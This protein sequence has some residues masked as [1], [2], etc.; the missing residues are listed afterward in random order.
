MLL[1]VYLTWSPDPHYYKLQPLPTHSVTKFYLWS[2]GA[3][4]LH[5]IELLSDQI[6]IFDSQVKSFD[7]NKEMLRI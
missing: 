4:I 3:H 5:F 1:Y 7:L 2:S 6:K